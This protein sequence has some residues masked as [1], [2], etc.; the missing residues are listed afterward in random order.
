M[1]RVYSQ[2]RLELKLH[3]RVKQPILSANRRISF[4]LLL[5]ITPQNEQEVTTTGWGKVVDAVVHACDFLEHRRED[6]LGIE[7]F[8]VA[9]I[10]GVAAVLQ[11]KVGQIL[12]NRL[13]SWLVHRRRRLQPACRASG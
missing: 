1:M 8:A 7:L 13:G 2:S 4:A 3:E 5:A 9:P 6:Q 12:D 11:L 10:G